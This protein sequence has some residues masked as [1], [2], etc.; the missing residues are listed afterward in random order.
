MNRFHARAIVISAGI[1]IARLAD[2]SML[3]DRATALP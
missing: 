1:G 2:L 3:N